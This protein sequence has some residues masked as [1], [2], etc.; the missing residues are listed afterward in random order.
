MSSVIGQTIII[1]VSGGHGFA[2]LK[3]TFGESGKVVTNNYSSDVSKLKSAK[4]SFG[5]GTNFRFDLIRSSGKNYNLGISLNYHIGQPFVFSKTTESNYYYSGH[6]SSSIIKEVTRYN[7]ISQVQF[8]PFLKL[9]TQS[10][11]N[12][13]MKLGGVFGCWGRAKKNYEQSTTNTY[14][15]VFPSQVPTIPLIHKLQIQ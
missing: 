10:E 14:D 3:Q 1:G 13:Y 12:L 7:E 8:I 9:S 2:A 5:E 4:T 6:H 15:V 11:I